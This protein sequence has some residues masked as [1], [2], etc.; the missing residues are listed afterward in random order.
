L[1]CGVESIPFCFL[2]LLVGA[3]SR[4]MSTWLLILDSTKKRLC[5][6]NDRL[7]SIGARVTLIN[8]VLSSLPL[9]FFSFFNVPTCVLKEL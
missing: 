7:L 8:S 4:R 1:H 3:N 6:W 2:G 9:Y 5:T